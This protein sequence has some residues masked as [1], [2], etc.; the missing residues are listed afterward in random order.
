MK[1]FETLAI[2]CGYASVGYALAKKNTLI[3]EDGESADTHFYLPLNDFRAVEYAP[4]TNAGQKLREIFQSF[5]FYNNGMLNLN[6]L[7]CAF[8][9]FIFQNNVN[10]YFR[11]NVISSVKNN[12]GYLVTLLT[13]SGL[14]EIKVKNI[15]DARADEQA[16]REITLLYATDTPDQVSKQLQNSFENSRIEKAFFD[17][18]YAIHIP[19]TKDYSQTLIYVL[20]K[21]KM[22]NPTAKIIAF[23][24]TLTLKG[25]GVSPLYDGRYSCPEQALDNGIILANGGAM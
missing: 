25:K 1:E 11:T 23:A 17:S 12:D 2:G 19:T 4:Q 10:V 20:D 15:I 9:D 21:W 18:R 6:G 24:P 3:V 13:V 14:T 22:V 8:C 16:K 5:D 7:E